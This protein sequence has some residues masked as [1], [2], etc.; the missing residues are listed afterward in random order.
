M[1]HGG[2]WLSLNWAMPD[3]SS[4]SVRFYL[5]SNV[6]DSDERKQIS[7][8]HSISS[9]RI[10]GAIRLNR[11]HDFRQFL[12]GTNG[13]RSILS[14]L[15]PFFPSVFP[16]SR[17]TPSFFCAKAQI[18]R[19][20]WHPCASSDFVFSTSTSILTAKCWINRNVYL[21]M[22]ECITRCRIAYS[23]LGTAMRSQRR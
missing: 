18:G 22:A 12:S 17:P 11:S 10:F 8:S 23:S 5:F 19:L 1:L 21:H 20:D 16:Y 9:F 2:L 7:A 4:L 13:H 6:R 14:H 15:F 3:D